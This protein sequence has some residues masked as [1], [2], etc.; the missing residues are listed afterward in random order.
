MDDYTEDAYYNHIVAQLEDD[1]DAL[2][3]HVASFREW[4]RCKAALLRWIAKVDV[5][6]DELAQDQEF[7]GP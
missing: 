4:T 5:E 1:D 2:L 7:G 3:G 6:H